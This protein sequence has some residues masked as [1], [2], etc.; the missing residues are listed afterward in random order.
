MLSVNGASLDLADFGLLLAINPGNATGGMPADWTAFFAG[1]PHSGSG[2]IAF[3]YTVG[4]NNH[5]GYI[6]V[7][8]VNVVPPL[9]LAS[10]VTCAPEPS[11]LPLTATALTIAIGSIAWRRRA[12]AHRR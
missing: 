2:R 4:P 7:D 8:N 1:L 6:G 3:E 11:S 12:A 5:A 9:C 10:T